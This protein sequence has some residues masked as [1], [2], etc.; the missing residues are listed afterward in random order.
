MK[1]A[2]SG[3]AFHSRAGR[4]IPV[5]RQTLSLRVNTIRLACEGCSP[6]GLRPVGSRSGCCPS[7]SPQGSSAEGANPAG[8]ETPKVRIPQGSSAEG[9]NHHQAF[10]LSVANGLTT[11]AS[12]C[13]FPLGLS[14]FAPSVRRFSIGAPPLWFLPG[15]MPFASPGGV[16]HRRCEHP[17]A[18]SDELK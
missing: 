3:L 18:R 5:T 14:P 17:E 2:F 4:S 9:V 8:A 1:R 10:G 11:R 12:P 13:R 6:P 15:L 16:G 7:R